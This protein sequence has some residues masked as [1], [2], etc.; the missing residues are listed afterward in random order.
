MLFQIRTV[1][2]LANRM[3]TLNQSKPE[4]KKK[5]VKTNKIKFA[6]SWWRCRRATTATS[7][8][9]LHVILSVRRLSRP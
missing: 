8:R 4:V 3:R 5:I 7:V 6:L 9:L 2:S 1:K